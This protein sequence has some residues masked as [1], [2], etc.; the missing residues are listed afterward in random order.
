[1]ATAAKLETPAF[2]G[3]IRSRDAARLLGM[4]EWSLRNLAHSGELAYIQRSSRAPMLFDPL[5]LRAWIE[6]QKIRGS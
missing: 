4:S 5:D 2:E 3:L 6:K 1:M